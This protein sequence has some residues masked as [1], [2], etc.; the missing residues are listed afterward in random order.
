MQPRIKKYVIES[1][2]VSFDYAALLFVVYFDR[3]SYYEHVMFRRSGSGAS[4]GKADFTES[5]L[6]PHLIGRRELSRKKQINFG[7]IAPPAE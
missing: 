4:N 1:G 3:S 2:I 5:L 7:Y 6:Q